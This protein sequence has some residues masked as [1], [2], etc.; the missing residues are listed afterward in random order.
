MHRSMVK[1][2]M[3]F[4]IIGEVRRHIF[5]SIKECLH[6]IIKHAEAQNVT[7]T[8]EKKASIEITIQDD[9]KGMASNSGKQIGGNGLKNI[10]NRMEKINA[11]FT[12]VNKN[13]TTILFQ[14]PY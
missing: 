7:I 11:Q 9:G 13:G 8:I 6:N 10:R 2:T 3:N 4:K 1:T 5:L 14:I 12:I